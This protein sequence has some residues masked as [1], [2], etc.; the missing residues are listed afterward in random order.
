MTMIIS[1]HLG[2]HIL[3]AADN[4][5]MI[6]DVET[7]NMSL[8]NNNEKKI[9]LW[10][11]GA[12]VGSGEIVFLNRVA[13]YFINFHKD[14]TQLKQMDAIYCEVEKRILE[15]IPKKMLINNI[16]IFSIFDGLK[17]FFYS[18]RIEPF[19]KS[20]EEDCTYRI[21]LSM[22][23]I[24]DWEVDVSCFN[25]PPDMTDLQKFQRDLKPMK[26]FKSQQDFINY[27]INK[28]KHIF[29]THALIDPSITT[30]FDLYIQSCETGS[31][32]TLHIPNYKLTSK[33]NE[34]Y[35]Y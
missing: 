5:S 34:K 25:I 23:E 11:R 32:F 17:T 27:Y 20:F 9:K 31:S 19:L 2:D 29:L 21:P 10:F 28:L 12:F 30:S 15:G 6:Y 14:M 13:Q 8:A 18:I 1:A 7:G 26:Y 35:S 22:I 3:I 4:R 24:R 33:I 16:V